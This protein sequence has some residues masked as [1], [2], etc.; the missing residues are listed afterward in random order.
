LDGLDQLVTS[1]SG[2]LLVRGN[3]DTLWFKD[4]GAGYDKAAGDTD[5]STLVKNGN[6][7]YTLTSKHGMVE[8]FGTTGL[9]TS[10]VDPSSKTTAFA[11]TDGDS[12][13]VNDELYTITDPYSRVLET[14]AYSSNK[15]SSFTDVAS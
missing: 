13:S 12:D 14:V 9:L 6:N 5:F 10:R 1:G 15:V 8:N 11:Y 7:T 2:A 4:N 3:G